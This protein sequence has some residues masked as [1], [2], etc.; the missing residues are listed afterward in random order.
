MYAYTYTNTINP[1]MIAAQTNNTTQLTPSI[2]LSLINNKIKEAL[3]QYTSKIEISKT[4]PNIDEMKQIIKTIVKENI[5]ELFPPNTDPLNVKQQCKEINQQLM[6]EFNQLKTLVTKYQQNQE[7]L[8]A[9][10]N[11]AISERDN[12]LSSTITDINL[13]LAANVTIGST[14]GNVT[15]RGNF[16]ANN[17]S[18]TGTVT[19]EFVRVS[20]LYSKR[21]PIAV[22]TNTIVD[23][24]VTTEY[25]SAKYTIKASNDVG[26]QALEVL[27]VHDNINS[28]IA[29]YGSLS[30]IGTD[31]ITLSTVINSGNVELK[32]TGLNANTMVN[33]M[34]TYVPD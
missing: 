19:A 25:R 15:A 32:A 26:Y 10:F 8:V 16:I 20:D 11:T 3:D 2:D 29:V 33:L 18:T 5:N 7:K 21:P 9:Q 17:V 23:S 30:T 22:T 34:G 4:L 6:I 27:L 28:I 12:K 13:G 24:F 14:A 31:I 1:F